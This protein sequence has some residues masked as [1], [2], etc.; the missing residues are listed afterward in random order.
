MQFLCNDKTFKV[1][2][3]KATNKC[4][5]LQSYYATEFQ[6]CARGPP[7]LCQPVLVVSHC[8]L[9]AADRVSVTSVALCA[10]GV[11]ETQVAW[12][13]ARVSGDITLAAGTNPDPG[14]SR[15]YPDTSAT[16]LQRP[17]LKLRVTTQGGRNSYLTLVTTI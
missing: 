3:C 4:Y 5:H 13:L 14:M 8:R 15:L 9:L 7:R 10:H 1:Q 12:E 17:D 6:P 16:Q 2:V 11:R